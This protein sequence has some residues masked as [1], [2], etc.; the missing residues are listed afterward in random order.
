MRKFLFFLAAV[1][2]AVPCAAAE[3]DTEVFSGCN[4]EADVPI[5]MYHL[6]TERSR[7]LGKYA[8]TPAELEQDLQF[9]SENG[10]STV[11]FRDLINFV[12]NGVPLPEKPVMLTFDDGNS[13]DYTLVLPLLEKYDMKIVSAIIGE[14][15]DRFTAESAANPGARYPNL[16]WPQIAE[17]HASGRVEIQS[18]SWN[19]HTEPLG[20][21]KK[22]SETVECY[23]TRLFDD[24]QRLQEACAMHLNYTP[25]AYVYPLGVIGDDS[26]KVLEQLGMSGSI[27]CQ[28][29]KNILRTG[30]SDCLFRLRRTNRPSGRGIEE[31]L[32]GIEGG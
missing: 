25:T 29:G 22:Q 26:R 17:L 11:V 2:F 6:I 3:F 31:V 1:F 18:H 12:E 9:L 5:V 32:R 4:R 27:S 7:Y 30:D 24:L 8:I 13:S 16:T 21:G 14:A 10:Y 19:L 15:A 20:S 28:E 23:H